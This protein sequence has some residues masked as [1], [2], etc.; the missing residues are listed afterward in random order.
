ML[1]LGTLKDMDMIK[2]FDDEIQGR[3]KE[4]LQTLDENYGTDRDIEHDLGGFVA[5]IDSVEDI[6][7][8]ETY[9]L[10]IEND[11]FEYEDVHDT[12]TERLYLLNDDY[13]VVVFFK[14]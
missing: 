5:V 4:C 10:D 7:E 6:E 9:Y 11:V 2:G 14:L 8:L 12:F 1:K 3:I 13:S